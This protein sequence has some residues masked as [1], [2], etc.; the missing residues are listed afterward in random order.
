MNI[1]NAEMNLKITNCTMMEQIWVDKK[2]YLTCEI[3]CRKRFLWVLVS[4]YHQR[5]WKEASWSCACSRG[6]LVNSSASC[7]SHSMCLC[8]HLRNWL[9]NDSMA[10]PNPFSFANKRS[11]LFFWYF[12]NQ[13]YL[14]NII[15][16]IFVVDYR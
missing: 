6:F 13:Q 11:T 9:C 1:E 8:V 5:G 10:V 4:V 14:N 15:L 7:G 12:T 16:V 3:K 2:K